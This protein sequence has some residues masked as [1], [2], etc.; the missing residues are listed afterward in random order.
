MLYLS[1]TYNI[2]QIYFKLWKM[3][4]NCGKSFFCPMDK[5]VISPQIEFCIENVD[6]FATFF[7][8]TST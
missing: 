2:I 7:F 6:F 4:E 3:H 5:E 8:K 1:D